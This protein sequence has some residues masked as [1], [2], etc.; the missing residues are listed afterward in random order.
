MLASCSACQF[1]PL[2]WE[3]NAVVEKGCNTRNYHMSQSKMVLAFRP[4]SP[5]CTFPTPPACPEA[6]KGKMERPAGKASWKGKP[7]RQAG[8]EA[9]KADGKHR[10]D[11]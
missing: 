9:E 10:L 8:Q 6:W 1:A 5:G 4:L 3:K 11:R 7:E 2:H